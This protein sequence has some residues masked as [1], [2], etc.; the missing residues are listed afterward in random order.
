[1]QDD[2]HVTAAI[3]ATYCCAKASNVRINS[4]LHPSDLR[5]LNVGS[6][7]LLCD[8]DSCFVRQ[9]KETLAGT[10]TCAIA[11]APNER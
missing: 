11:D 6:V 5:Y 10:E 3:F 1:M 7:K 8:F 9:S 4:R 2:V